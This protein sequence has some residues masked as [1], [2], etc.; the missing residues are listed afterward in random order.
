MIVGCHRVKYVSTSFWDKTYHSRFAHAEPQPHTLARCIHWM[1]LREL[2][3][4]PFTGPG[5]RLYSLG[6]PEELRVGALSSAWEMMDQPFLFW[7]SILDRW[8]NRNNK[9]I[10]VGEK[11][12]LRRHGRKASYIKLVS[13]IYSFLPTKLKL[14]CIVSRRAEP[15]VSISCLKN[16][17]NKSAKICFWPKNINL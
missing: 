12:S 9:S 6:M 17:Q 13:S 7:F 1:H 15:L 16:D 3:L 8:C 5:R 2:C 14:L 4:G 10:L 11:G